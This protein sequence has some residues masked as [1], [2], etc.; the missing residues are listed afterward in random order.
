MY[1]ENLSPPQVRPTTLEDLHQS[2][3]SKSISASKKAPF[4][5]LGIVH[6][7]RKSRVFDV[8]KPSRTSSV[9]FPAEGDN[10]NLNP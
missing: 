2:S 5:D 3:V 1:L 10:M 8:S 7:S 9:G 6:Q 4:L